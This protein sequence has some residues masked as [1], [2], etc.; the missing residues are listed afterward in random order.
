MDLSQQLINKI[1]AKHP[2][3]MKNF[4]LC[5]SFLMFTLGVKAQEQSMQQATTQENLLNYQGLAYV[6][7]NPLSYCYSSNGLKYG[8]TIPSYTIGWMESWSVNGWNHFMGDIGVSIDWTHGSSGFPS[9]MNS[10][11]T[12]SVNM[13]TF[14]LNMDFAYHNLF[15]T[16]HITIDP[17]IGVAVQYHTLGYMRI[18]S[19]YMDDNKYKYTGETADMFSSKDMGDDEFKA[20]SVYLRGGVKFRFYQRY[21]A[22]IAYGCDITEI[23]NNTHRRGFNIALG[24]Y[25]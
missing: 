4:I 15:N 12:R 3:N 17:F 5:A 21:Y 9:M 13:L 18:K 10:L 8:V 22:M 19:Y 6:G 24:C 7:I 23:E 11:Q 14:N 25:F 16:S 1:K 2:N 20:F